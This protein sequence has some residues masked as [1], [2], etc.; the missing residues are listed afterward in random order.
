MTA[1]WLAEKSLEK[2]TRPVG[3]GEAPLGMSGAVYFE[4]LPVVR[5]LPREKDLRA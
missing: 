3:S 4:A 2:T 5:E 1:C